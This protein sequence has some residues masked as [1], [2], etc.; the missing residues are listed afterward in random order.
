MAA[1][2]DQAEE[3]RSC[4]WK[5]GYA[6]GSEEGRRSYDEQLSD[7]MREN[8]ESLKRVLFELYE[9]RDR[10]Y[11]GLEA[12]AVGLALEVVRKIFNPAEGELSGVFM[13]LIKNAMKQIAPDGKIIIRVG[14]V[15]Y[16]NFFASGSTVIELEGGVT[17]TAS[18]LRD[19]S[20]TKGDC[21]IDTEVATIN[22][23]IESQLKHIQLAFSRI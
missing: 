21:I 5:E 3:E 6:E 23:G 11:S 2:R 18:V 20:L 13:S 22:A 10:T 12:E 14:P 4:A 7:K 19:I 15:E 1:A 9:E 8:E 17:V 16:E